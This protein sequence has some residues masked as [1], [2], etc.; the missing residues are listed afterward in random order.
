MTL[1]LWSPL[2]SFFV[3]GMHYAKF[4]TGRKKTLTVK[5]FLFLQASIK[6]IS[7]IIL[8]VPKC[9]HNI[10]IGCFGNRMNKSY[11][12][13]TTLCFFESSQY[14]HTTSQGYFVPKKRV[15]SV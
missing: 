9:L 8:K 5:I 7:Q 13:F 10:H 3:M 15:Q 12:P 14:I 11:A 1:D 6:L 2:A 4:T